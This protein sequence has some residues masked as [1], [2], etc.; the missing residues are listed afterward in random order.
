MPREVEKG[1][2]VTSGC[3]NLSG[4]LHIRTSKSFGEST[5]SKI[6]QLVEE[7]DAHKSR[8]ES[9]ITRF[10]RVY[11]PIVVWAAV[12]LA[13]IPPLFADAGFAQAFPTW[14]HRA[15]IFW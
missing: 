15:L 3:I 7:A 4:V 6:I 5:V 11:T 2:E 12:A 9:F 1:D 10:A 13:I 8:S 14:L